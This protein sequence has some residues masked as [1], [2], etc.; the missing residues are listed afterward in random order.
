[1]GGQ[2]VEGAKGSQFHK[3]QTRSETQPDGHV[4]PLPKLTS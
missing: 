1:M 4:D 2:A 3:A